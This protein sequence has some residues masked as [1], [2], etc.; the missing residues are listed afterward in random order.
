MIEL[1]STNSM[2]VSLESIRLGTAGLD[3]H[4]SAMLD[5]VP[6]PGMYTNFPYEH[7]AMKDLAYLTAATGDEFA[8]LRGKRADI[9]FHGFHNRCSFDETLTDLLICKKFHLFGHSHPGEDIPIASP[10]DRRTLRMI[11][12]TTSRIISARTGIEREFGIDQ[13][14]L[15]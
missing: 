6:A 1:A 11:G 7:L 10:E 4:R 14:E 2:R 9:L 3:S 13:F 12:Q 5:R 15:L 8:I